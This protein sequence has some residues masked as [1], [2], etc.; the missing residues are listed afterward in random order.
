MF[1]LSEGD[2]TGAV[3]LIAE[4]AFSY[5]AIGSSIMLFFSAK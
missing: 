4:A 2:I 3:L 5:F 1:F